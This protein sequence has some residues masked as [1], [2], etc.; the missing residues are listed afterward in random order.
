MEYLLSY[1]DGSSKC[2]FHR[3]V[4][5]C[6]F[7]SN[8]CVCCNITVRCS[9]EFAGLCSLWRMND[10]ESGISIVCFIVDI[11]P[12]IV[13]IIVVLT[14]SSKRSFLFTCFTHRCVNWPGYEASV[15]QNNMFLKRRRSS[16]L[17]SFPLLSIYM[18]YSQVCELTWIWSVRSANNITLFFYRDK[19]ELSSPLLLL[20]NKSAGTV[21][22][23]PIC[24]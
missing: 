22:Y 20:K 15:V 9:D 16:P 8:N 2:L 6:V 4:F 14:L 5:P 19:M 18:F 7:L 23:T 3:F 17:L 10:P 24:T 11:Y 13:V 1:Q 21:I 12:M